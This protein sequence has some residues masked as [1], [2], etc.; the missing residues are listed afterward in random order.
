MSVTNYSTAIFLFN[1]KV[2]AVLAIYE[3]D[4]K[5]TKAPRTMFKTLDSDIKVDDFVLVP[6]NTRHNMTVVKVTDVGVEVDLESSIKVDWIIGPIDRLHYEQVLSMEAQ[7]V[8]AIKSAQTTR[9][10]NE[11]R[12]ALLADVP[13]DTIK[14]LPIAAFNGDYAPTRTK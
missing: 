4:T 6:T 7:A 10:R 11:L 14:A 5:D 13:V 1:N 9:K 12:E 3:A 8:N 2:R